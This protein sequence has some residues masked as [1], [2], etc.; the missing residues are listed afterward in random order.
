MVGVEK[1]EWVV[2]EC[3]QSGGLIDLNETFGL[4]P[5]S[6]RL[7]FTLVRTLWSRKKMK[8]AIVSVCKLD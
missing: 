1:C 8:V 6:V 4:R 2:S 3:R 5:C 7:R